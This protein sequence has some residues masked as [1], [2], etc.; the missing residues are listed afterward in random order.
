VYGAR[1]TLIM[2]GCVFLF[3]HV[4]GLRGGGVLALGSMV[5]VSS[6]VFNGNIA[7]HGGAIA[8]VFGAVLGVTSG[9]RFEANMAA[10]GGAIIGDTDTTVEVSGAVQFVGNYA[11]TRFC[12]D[13]QV[14]WPEMIIGAAVVLTNA[15]T[16]FVARGQVVFRNGFSDQVVGAVCGAA[17]VLEF[18]DGVRIEGNLAKS[19]GGGVFAVFYPCVILMDGSIVVEDNHDL[20]SSTWLTGGGIWNGQSGSVFLSNG[21]ILRANSAMQGG[22]FH[23]DGIQPWDGTIKMDN[24]TIMDNFARGNGG[25]AYFFGRSIE[26][27]RILFKNNVCGGSAGGAMFEA[28][29]EVAMRDCQF[30]DNEAAEN[31]GA[32]EGNGKDTVLNV[33][34]TIFQSNR[35]LGEG[36]GIYLGGAAEA[37]LEGTSVADC[38]A[39][40]NGGGIST[41]GSSILTLKGDVVIQKCASMNGMGG[42][43]LVRRKL[44]E[45]V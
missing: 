40:K 34:S 10:W 11:T 38:S 16:R 29:S 8:A 19:G 45:I 41:R 24:I 15:R 43:M 13:P 4:D 26:L 14:C 37:T 20:G 17:A 18:Y 6:S 12:E 1:T 32:L 21:V 7:L 28:G 33:E 39:D 22:G 23:D 30:I 25:G 9:V 42:G 35:A 31:G 27:S 2:D 44:L 5:N 3:N 36:G